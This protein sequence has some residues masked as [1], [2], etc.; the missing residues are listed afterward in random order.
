[1]ILQQWC[2]IL[3]SIKL[4]K[5]GN[6]GRSG[7]VLF[8]SLCLLVWRERRG[9]EGFGGREIK[10]NFLYFLKKYFFIENDK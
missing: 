4:N 8:L 9:E 6:S 5:K 1:M 7:A 2:N 10:R 3:L